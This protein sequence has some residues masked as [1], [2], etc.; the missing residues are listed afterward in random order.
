MCVVVHIL[1]STHAILMQCIISKKIDHVE[2]IKL[3]KCPFL[4]YPA[5]LGRG[6]KLSHKVS[7]GFPRSS[8][9]YTYIYVGIL[10]MERVAAAAGLLHVKAKYSSSIV[11]V[12]GMQSGDGRCQETS[13]PC[14]T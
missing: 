14:D 3:A 13:G 9:Y 10:R 6:L 1:T 2:M 12:V 4:L 7:A 11:L 8:K 5:A